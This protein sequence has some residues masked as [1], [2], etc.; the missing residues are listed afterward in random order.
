MSEPVLFVLIIMVLLLAVSFMMPLADRISVPATI[1][2]AVLGTALG[3]GSYGIGEIPDIGFA[4]EV[5]HGLLD[6]KLDADL[7]LVLFLPPLLFTAGLTIDVRLVMNE[8]AAVLLLAIVAVFVT[9]AAAGWALFFVSGYVGQVGLFTC[10]LLGAVIATTD[11]AAVIAIFRD[12][13][14]PR[15]L[16]ALVSGESTLNDAAAIALFAILID[17][18]VDRPD[19]N[20]GNV[21]ITLTRDFIGGIAVGF[22]AAQITS[23]L[24]RHL[25]NLPLAEITVSVALA[26]VTYIMGDVLVDVSGV[27][28]V[29]VAAMTF[30]VEGRSR[31]SPG[32]WEKLLQT[33]YQ[34]D[35]WAN[36]LI[37]VLA[38]MLAT[39]ILPSAGLDDL[40]FL[41]VLVLAAF[42]GRAFVLYALLP[43]LSTLRVTAPIGGRYKLVLLWG[44]L[45]GAITLTLAVSVSQHNMIPE[46]DR[47]FVSVLATAY[48]L[49]TLF[50]QAPTLKPLL[51]LL[52]LDQLNPNELALRDGVIAL[53]KAQVRN[54]IEEVT[55]DYGFD[56]ELAEPLYEELIKSG[57]ALEQEVQAAETE[58]DGS[59][60][61]G[62]PAA[63][64][65]SEA[66]GVAVG[67]V[68]LTNRE[69]EIYLEH[70]QDGTISRNRVAKLITLVDGLIDRVKVD[71]AK[72]YETLTNQQINLTMR[73]RVS[74]R[75]YRHIGWG[76][77][78]STWIADRFERLLITQLVVRDLVR[79]NKR[80]IRPLLGPKTSAVL[81]GILNR[82]LTSLDDALAATDLQ[83][84]NFTK[85]LRYQYLVRAALRLE[86]GSYQHAL[87]E[88]LISR[89]VYRELERDIASRRA[90]V[91]ERPTLDLGTGLVDMVSRVRVFHGLKHEDLL[92]VV[93][94]LRPRLAVPGQRILRKG[95]KGSAMYFIAAGT[96]EVGL[97]QG[98]V[99]LGAGEFVGEMALL[100]GKP[101]S[102][103][104]RALTYCHLLG[105]SKRDFQKLL[106]AKP[107]IKE[108]IE[109]IAKDRQA[110]NLQNKEE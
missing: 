97:P 29:V 36:S 73:A 2:L 85:E 83:Y 17:A 100:S 41:A 108:V 26:Y 23:S 68:A 4:G 105:L 18:V 53:S 52:R 49:F 58:G 45:R 98:A 102:A 14:A 51:R 77:P 91:E 46:E 1:L 61:P 107:W 99:E 43:V 48:V 95:D 40:L 20:V 22:I 16:T 79:F 6:L 63:A 101:R 19:W 34:L 27:V 24:L 12:L 76:G 92:D 33:W 44:G 39:R 75:L 60:P 110:I 47:H 86:H 70:F 89:E 42:A 32:T 71:G 109:K 5:V 62:K 3:L 82:R 78:L 94:L 64:Q 66:A 21:M 80:S 7:I 59:E 30:A 93:R 25:F 57:E 88:S 81:D 72:G 55:R 13:G 106:K 54:D 15:R 35:F 84:P 103:N 50:V 96:V 90:K 31:L 87:A 10:M 28:A 104:V 11:P 65:M 38:A 74:L 37:F 69:K 56:P 67:L 8:M 9:T